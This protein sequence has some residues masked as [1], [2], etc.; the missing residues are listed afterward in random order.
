MDADW[1]V[2]LSRND[3]PWHEI[4][5][6]PFTA[7]ECYEKY[8]AIVKDPHTFLKKVLGLKEKY[9]KMMEPQMQIMST[10]TA[11]VQH[12]N[13]AVYCRCKG[14]VVSELFVKCDGDQ[15]CPNGSWLHP[16]C[17]TDLRE[18]SKEELDTMEEWY[19]EDCLAR[20]RREEEEH[21]TVH[22]DEE[23]D[24]DIQLDEEGE[25]Q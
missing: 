17:T 5:F 2:T 15:E 22:A 7:K 16:Q 10:A 1:T 14:G 4:A 25:A 23:E 8:I 20:I 9:K 12:E 13:P 19:C 24:V 6:L 21:A 11:A 18:K 3:F